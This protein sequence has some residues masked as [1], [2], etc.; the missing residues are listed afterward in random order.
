MTS[1]EEMA[2]ESWMAQMSSR[3]GMGEMIQ[4]I[5]EQTLASTLFDTFAASFGATRRV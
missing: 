2:S 4:S 3:L 5:S 1:Q